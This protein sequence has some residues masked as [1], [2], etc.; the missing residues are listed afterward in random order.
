MVIWRLLRRNLRTGCFADRVDLQS[1][2]L[3]AAAT[4][5]ELVSKVGPAMPKISYLF[6]LTALTVVL[7]FCT[8]ATAFTRHLPSLFENFQA[9]LKLSQSF[10][11]TH[12]QLGPIQISVPDVHAGTKAGRGYSKKIVAVG[13]LHGD[14]PNALKVLQI[15]HVVDASGDWSGEIDSF[16]QTGDIIDR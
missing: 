14:M 12:S 16:V 13:D 10:F 9:Y 1:P 2:T 8:Q 15:A 7:A 6:P 5:F 4:S 3:A 11:Q